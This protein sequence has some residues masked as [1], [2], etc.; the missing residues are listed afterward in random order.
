MSDTTQIKTQLHASGDESLG[1]GFWTARISWI[2]VALTL[3]LL[4]PGTSTL[5]LIDRDE[6]RFAQATREMMERGEWVL[7]YFNQKYRF[8]KPILSYWL[9]RASYAVFGIHEFSARLH[10]IMCVAALSVVVYHFGV[11]LKNART[12]LYAAVGVLTCLQML[13]HGRST[14]A[15]MPMILAIAVTFR[16]LYELLI[17]P[18]EKYPWKWFWALYLSQG[19]GFLA[20]GPVTQAVPLVALLIF[21]WVLW[22]KPL[23]WKNLKI[24]PGVLVVLFLISLWGIPAL[25]KT[26]GKFWADGMNK[27]ILERGVVAY[28]GRNAFFVYYLVTALMSLM[29]WVA[30]AGYGAVY[31]RRNWNE[32]MA[33]LTAW[34]LA[35]YVI[36]SCYATQLPH[37]VMPA[38]AA[39]FL[40]LALAC[41]KEMTPSRLG[42]GVFSVVMLLYCGLTLVLMVIFSKTSFE[43][44]SAGFSPLLKGVISILLGM[45]Y[46]ALFFHQKSFKAMMIGVI[47]VVLGTCFLSRGVRVML[48][49]IPIALETRKMPNGS[50]FG[51]FKYREPSLVYYSNRQWETLDKIEEV[52]SFLKQTG[53]R[54]LVILEQEIDLDDWLRHRFRV[55]SGKASELKSNDYT[56]EYQSLSFTGYRKT[57]YEGINP[58]RSSW[59]R[60]AVYERIEM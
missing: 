47:L 15:D 25:I 23:A 43:G 53:P 37:Y 12:G 17:M 13:I 26:K 45:V 55:F 30:F 49:T 60:V 19:L 14:V 52:E 59:V 10:S 20:K 2:L 29:P 34:L 38:F 11:R 6:P 4:V 35:P 51:F 54:Q 27:H 44:I 50:A 3:L 32:R 48:P 46:L 1:K 18:H 58:A 28:N 21:R 33:F 8:D 57:L 24:V 31:L 9:M 40:I 5:P 39:I 16:A 41:E 42:I 36:F 22:R 7:P 56:S